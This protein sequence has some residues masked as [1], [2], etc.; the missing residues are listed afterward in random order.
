VKAA[1][2]WAP[3]DVRIEELPEPQ[4]AAGELVVRVEAALTC[5]TDAKC[6]RRGHPVLLG[7]APARFGHEYAGTVVAAGEGAPFAPGARVCG[8]N[9]APCGVCAACRRGRE[10]LCDDLYP[11]LNGA[12]AELLLVPARIA[13][14]NVHAIPDGIPAEVAAAIEPLACAVHAA[15]DVGAAPGVH[16]AVLGRGPL[17]RMIALACEAR[18][19]T[20][21]LVG[22]DEPRPDASF[23]AV[24][25]AA[26]TVEAWERAVALAA[27]GGTVVLFGGPPRGTVLSVDTYRVHYEALTL[28]GS[29][30]HRPRDVRAAL[31]LIAADPAPIASLLTHEF[32]LDRV[33]EPLRRVAGLEPRDG[34]LKAVIRPWR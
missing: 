26:G 30:H 29:F 27:P 5:G 23:E 13:A 33:V 4:P 2:F 21:E 22:R 32:A 15:E 25:E 1:R 14:V 3:L 8:A 28:R 12:Y 16:V 31:E 7:P 19:A 9:S 10:E 18:G 11:L 34:L 17:G 24:V 20:S 6:Y